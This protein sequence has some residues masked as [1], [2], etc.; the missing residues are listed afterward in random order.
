MDEEGNWPG[1]CVVGMSPPATPRSTRR[2][3]TLREVNAATVEGVA[4]FKQ[5]ML[6][7]YTVTF[8]PPVVL[9]IYF[10]VALAFIL[11]G[12]A[13]LARSVDI[14]D[15]E[16]AVYTDLCRLGRCC[17]V[18]VNVARRI[19]PNYFYD[20]ITNLHRT[21]LDYVTSLSQKQLR[22][23]MPGVCL[24]VAGCYPRQYTDSERNANVQ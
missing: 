3:P 11:L 22:V 9:C 1:G 20:V 2:L 8:S 21:D 18:P 24:Y 10:A 14:R 5:Q 17:V 19:P 15:T 7:S 12:A 16:R 13:I 4:R 23:E 6:K